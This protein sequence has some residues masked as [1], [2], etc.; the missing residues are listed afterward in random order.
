SLEHAFG[1]A[2]RIRHLINSRELVKKAT[3][4]N[5]GRISVSIGVA[6]LVAGDTAES[7]LNRADM[8]MYAA[9]NSGRNQVMD[10][11]EPEPAAN[12]AA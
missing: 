2:E 3:N 12:S 5:M 7:F 11:T 6:E 1:V 10:T 8:C 9:K 4:E